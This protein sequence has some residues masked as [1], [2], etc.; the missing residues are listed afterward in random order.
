MRATTRTSLARSMCVIRFIGT[1]S[2]TKST[3]VDLPNL[4]IDRCAPFCC[5][6]LKD[7]ADSP[8]QKL[9]LRS[10]RPLA[11]CRCFGMVSLSSYPSW[12]LLIV[13]TIVFRALFFIEAQQIGFNFSSCSPAATGYSNQ[14]WKDTLDEAIGMASNV[15]DLLNSKDVNV[16]LMWTTMIADIPPLNGRA[17]SLRAQQVISESSLHTCSE[18]SPLK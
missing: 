8:T 7:I 13:W 1:S 9:G 3:R 18:S 14:E 5:I 16:L 12:V 10:L 4:D 2:E 17:G 6:R 15:L 11:R